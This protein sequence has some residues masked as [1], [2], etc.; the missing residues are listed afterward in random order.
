[1]KQIGIDAE[2]KAR[3][4]DAFSNLT[5]GSKRTIDAISTD[6]GGDTLSNELLEDDDWED[7]ESR[8]PIALSAEGDEWKYLLEFAGRPTKRLVSQ[9]WTQRIENAERRWNEQLPL[10]ID[11]FLQFTHFPVDPEPLSTGTFIIPAFDVYDY[12]PSKLF[13]HL[14]DCPSLN[15]TFLRQGYLGATP[16]DV[17]SVISIRTLELY[18]RLRLRQ[19]RVS[20]QA[21]VR[22]ICDLHNLTYERMYW[23]HF[24]DTFDVYL[25]I[26]AGAQARV[27]HELGRSDADWRIR[28]SCPCCQYKLLDD[29][30]LQVEIIGAMDGNQSLKR[31]RLREG[32]KADP[33]V[34]KS[35]YYISEDD[36]DQFKYDVKAQ[37]A[38]PNPKP[39]KDADAVP[40]GNVWSDDTQ[41]AAPTDGDEAGTTCTERWK[42]AM[43]DSHKR[44]WAIYRETGIFLS[45]C[46][47]G[48]IWW[49]CDMVESGELAKYPLA[50]VSKVL[51]L[52]DRVGIGYDIGCSF[53]AT[54]RKSSLSATA[55]ARC[56]RLF[57][58]S[59]HGYAHRRLCQL[60]FHPL[61]SGGGLGLEDA[62]TCER[63]FAAFN[64]LAII[65]RYASPFHRHQAI[66]G[67]ARGWDDDK[68][69]ELSTFLLN[70]YRQI[71]QILTELPEAIAALQV[72]KTVEDT[73]YHKHLE[74]EREYLESRKKE[75][76]S[77]V[78]ACDYIDIL[79]KHRTAK[80]TWEQAL[81]EAEN[82]PRNEEL[83]GRINIIKTHATEQLQIISD[84]L[85]QFEVKHNWTKAEGYLTTRDYQKAL[86]KLEGL[87]VQRLFE[88]AKMGLS[89]TGYKMRMHINKSLKTRCRAIQRALDKYN[90]A[91][92]KIARPVLTWKD[93]STYGSL[94][95]F[96]LLHESQSDIRRLPWAD[97]AN[98]Q[99]ALHYL[100]IERAE[101]ERHRVNREI[102]RLVTFMR[103]EE[104]DLEQRIRICTE[105]GSQ[106]S[107]L[108]AAQL[109]AY[110]ARRVRVNNIHRARLERIF[111]L[112]S[113]TGN[114]HAGIAV[115]R[116]HEEIDRSQDEVMY[117]PDQLLDDETMDSIGAEEDD[118]VG[119]QLD[120]LNEWVGNLSMIDAGDDGNN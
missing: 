47:H 42:A 70:N 8:N 66:D 7:I 95:E 117:T 38:A 27:N 77:E 28:H 104:A 37:P 89:G 20:I 58:N 105:E 120:N 115:E 25:K 109:C 74:A 26:L 54:I 110:Q 71:E 116:A 119:E 48:M 46:R 49:I 3:A 114:R 4:Q 93:V 56:L 65:T 91:A 97:S 34:F 14:P 22:V 96:E 5:S 75:T 118:I 67:H 12:H 29:P 98:R 90:T 68:Y 16:H 81:V 83:R 6:E 94:A 21:W 61:F 99:A 62:E 11:A 41:A 51:T 84:L 78:F 88:L 2:Y 50:I 69:E 19:P 52:G 44:M 15:V 111:A 40:S 107:L 76:P 86:S 10:L 31:V 36:V 23:Q 82:P 100:K 18:R 108:L 59:F 30:D 9:S 72:G 79:I 85:H 73:Q 43:S 24:T 60:L 13:H 92:K 63:I 106:Q 57:V 1:M 101:E 39:N 102:R 113:F 35:T 17:S 112:P 87:V 32:L 80:A 103:D 33:R 55:K 53:T 45:A 64:A